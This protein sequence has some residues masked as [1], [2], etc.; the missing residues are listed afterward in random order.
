VP[1]HYGRSSSSGSRGSAAPGGTGGGGGGWSPGVGGKQ[2]QPK[3]KS[4]AASVS[5]GGGWTPGVGR[6]K[7]GY[8]PSHPIH[9]SGAGLPPQLGGSSSAAQAA[10]FIPPVIPKEEHILEG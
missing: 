3:A 5:T 1:G 6:S 4:K 8:L 2:H 10:K 9:G 7:T